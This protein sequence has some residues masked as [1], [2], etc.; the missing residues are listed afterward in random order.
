[1]DYLSFDLRIGEWNPHTGT[2]VV[3]VLHSPSGEGRRYPFALDLDVDMLAFGPGSEAQQGRAVGRQLAA[4]LFRP[5]ILLAWYESYQIARERQTGLRL[6][7]HIESWELSGLP[8]EL[9]YDARADDYMVFDERVSI[10][11]YIRLHSAP[12]VLRHSTSLRLLAVAASPI[13]QSPL[14]WRNEVTLLQDAIAPLAQKGTIRLDVCEHATPQS[15]HVALLEN[16]PDVVH[17]VGHAEYDLAEY[18]G[19]IVLEDDQHH[20]TFMSATEAARLLR[21][22]GT[23]LVV[24]NACETAHG[25]WAGLASTLVR[26]EVPAV[27]A[28]QWP[29]EDRAAI[30][31]S[32][33]FYRTLTAGKTVDECVSEGRVAMDAAAPRTVSWAAPVLFLRSHSGQL[34]APARTSAAQGSRLHRPLTAL[35]ELPEDE[36]DASDFEEPLFR[37]PGPLRLPEDRDL[38]IAR[39]E[40]KRALGLAQQPSV[41]QYIALLSARQTGKTTLLLQM[42]DLLQDLYACI[43]VDLSALRGQDAH[44]CFRYVAFRLLDE[45]A[46]LLGEDVGLPDR[47]RVESPVDFIEFLYAL[48]KVAPL[49][50][51]IVLIDEVGALSPEASDA[52]FNTVRT[53][54]I[55][56][57]GL[58]GYLAKYLFVFSGAVDLYGLTFGT[59]SPLNICE[60]IYLQDLSPDDVTQIVQQFENVGVPVEK[61]AAKEVYALTAGHPYLTVR[62][63]ALLEREQV[64]ALSARAVRRAGE[65]ILIEDDNIRHLLHELE[66]M[67]AARRQMHS[68]LYS[69]RH[70]PFSRNN[71]IL[72]SLEM[73]G[74]IRPTQPCTVRNRLYA[75]A[76]S[77][78]FGE[79]TQ[80][81]P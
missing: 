44:A 16:T 14:D 49:P 33:A 17:F 47:H 22:Y 34:W 19:Y 37:T 41:G 54:F 43:F 28:M 59:N 79:Q 60:K 36:Q 81:S 7:L 39:P 78:Y 48:A 72:A 69:G 52:F 38:I 24:L 50:R 56:G 32:Q 23:N 62:L 21:R 29:I 67:P 31:F 26:T 71:P 45:F 64:E 70:T 55:Q 8:W 42:R 12:P 18:Q 3:E 74:A 58:T 9:L 80:T 30:H 77:E 1:M 66:R 20:A 13:D 10:A 53:V 61:N 46:S 27:V 63:C 35:G 25:I 75:R 73:I 15:L 11:R 6:R 76:L 51:I 40:L 57:R 65:Q 2:G 4:A 68:I 5:E